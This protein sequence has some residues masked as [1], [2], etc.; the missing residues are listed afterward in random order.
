MGS[1]SPRKGLAVGRRPGGAPVPIVHGVRGSIPLGLHAALEFWVRFPFERPQSS[2]PTWRVS[3]RAALSPRSS[4]SLLVALFLPLLSFPAFAQLSNKRLS[5][6]LVSGLPN[7]N[8]GY[9]IKPTFNQKK[10]AEAVSLAA[11]PTNNPSRP[12]SLRR[13]TKTPRLPSLGFL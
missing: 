11:E 5:L 12:P 2:P 1:R 4:P 3:A 10:A 8:R 6:S 9:R 13:T 7:S